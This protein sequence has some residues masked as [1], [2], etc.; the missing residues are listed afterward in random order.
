MSPSTSK[1]VHSISRQGYPGDIVHAE[2]IMDYIAYV[3]G[4][5]LTRDN[6]KQSEN[7]KCRA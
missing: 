3:T 7:S 2:R 6:K 4:V 5:M 1:P